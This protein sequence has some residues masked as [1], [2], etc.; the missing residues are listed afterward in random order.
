MFP[1]VLPKQARMNLNPSKVPKNCNRCCELLVLACRRT[2]KKNTCRP[3]MRINFDPNNQFL[4][5]FCCGMGVATPTVHLA[6]RTTRFVAA[7]G[8][9]PARLRMC[10]EN[11]QKCHPD[12]WEMDFD[13]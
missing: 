1:C 13:H 9:V 7:K 8:K 4:L 11:A 10:A 2:D 6:A 5:F 3:R 12:H